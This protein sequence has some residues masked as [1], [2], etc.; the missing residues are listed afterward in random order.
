M[1]KL[2]AIIA[3][4]LLYNNFSFADEVDRPEFNNSFNDNIIKY[5]WKNAGS[6]KAQDGI[7]VQKLKNGQWH[8][9]CAIVIKKT[10]CW[11]P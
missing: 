9:Y 10:I 11:L 4:S 2:L 6:F 8:L 7:T 5:K 3:L 1:K